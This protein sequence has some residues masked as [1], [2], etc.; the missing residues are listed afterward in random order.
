MFQKYPI[1]QLCKIQIDG[2]YNV[3]FNLDIRTRNIINLYFPL[4]YF[5][6]NTGA[7]AQ[8]KPGYPGEP[9]EHRVHR[10]REKSQVGSVPDLYPEKSSSEIQTCSRNFNFHWYGRM[11]SKVFVQINFSIFYC[12]KNKFSASLNIF[13]RI[14]IIIFFLGG[15]T[16]CFQIKGFYTNFFT[17]KNCTK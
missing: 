15:E 17:E 16:L 11:F 7:E 14:F 10:L 4:L 2:G 8:D 13:F 3:V 1:L 6:P 12:L 5:V 9:G